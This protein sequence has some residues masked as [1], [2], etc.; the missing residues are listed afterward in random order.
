LEQI[1]FES[2]LSIEQT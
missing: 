1:T 2:I